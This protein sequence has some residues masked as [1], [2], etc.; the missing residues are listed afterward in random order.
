MYRPGRNL[1]D[2]WMELIYKSNKQ[3]L[4]PDAEKL[5]HNLVYYG[6]N[7]PFDDQNLGVD[8]SNARKPS[9]GADY[10]SANKLTDYM[11]RNK[12]PD[13]VALKTALV[14]KWDK[15]K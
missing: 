3:D 7:H 5:R 12:Y 2:P 8:M 9:S 14:K 15:I 6:K 4:S 13:T 11:R 1:M 10:D